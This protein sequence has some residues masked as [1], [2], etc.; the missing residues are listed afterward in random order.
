VLNNEA[1]MKRHDKNKQH[2]GQATIEFTFGMIVT[3]LLLMGMVQ[4]L[5]WTGQDLAKRRAGH[6]EHLILDVR[7]T[8]QTDPTFYYS[9]T[10]AAPVPT[11]IFGE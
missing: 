1:E 7:G 3:V 9:T 4:V 11:N 5:I 8:I 6:E 10:V 2:A